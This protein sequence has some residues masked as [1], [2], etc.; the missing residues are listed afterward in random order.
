M[1]DKPLADRLALVT[2]A[3]RG[4]GAATA[5]ALATA[6]AHVVLVA[7]TTGGLEAVEE[8]IH[9]AGGAATIAPLDLTDNDSIAR[10]AA[11]MAERWPALDLM[12]LNA[13]ML[14]SLA[15]VQA[16]D[17]KEFARTLTLNVVAQQAMIAAFDPMLRAAQGGGQLIGLTSTVAAAPRA[18]WG[19]YGA[20]KAALENLLTAYA[21]EQRNLGKV[22][23]AI[24]NPGATRTKMRESA[25]PGEAPDSVKPPEVVADRLLALLTE[26]F[27]TGHRESIAG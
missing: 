10:L 8:D 14:G 17:G 3:S 9:N 27:P 24:V 25:Y 19:G 4:I 12:I 20:S 23:V 1:T 11:A 13:G 26:G 21:E 16:I 6:G 7:R 15:P 22:R 2:G 18:Y 5:R